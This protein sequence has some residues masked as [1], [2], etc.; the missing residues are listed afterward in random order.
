MS[1]VPL[2]LIWLVANRSHGGGTAAAPSMPAWPTP[3][4]PPPAPPA[5][6][7]AAFQPQPTTH[8]ESGTPLQELHAATEQPPPANAIEP[9]QA[10]KKKAK[11]KSKLS[12]AK[13]KLSSAKSKLST[14]KAAADSQVSSVANLQSILNARGAK[15]KKDGLY[16]PKTAQAWSTAARKQSLSPTIARVGPTVARVSKQTFESLKTPPAP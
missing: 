10:A 4:S 14:A 3:A 6:L 11:P 9:A 16:G 13:S 8:A 5:P 1:L 12:T 7:P 2:F 15:L